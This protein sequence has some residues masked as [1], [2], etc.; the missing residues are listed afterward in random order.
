MDAVQPLVS[1]ALI[2]TIA[3]FTFANLE[4]ALTEIRGDLRAARATARTRR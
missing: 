3:L 2:A 1:A 4:L